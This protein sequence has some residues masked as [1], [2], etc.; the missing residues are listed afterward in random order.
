MNEDPRRLFTVS[1]T[2]HYIHRMQKGHGNAVESSWDEA[3]FRFRI[4]ELD[5]AQ[6]GKIHQKGEFRGFS[7]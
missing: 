4:E 7:L 1:L 3:W 6:I 2:C 5:F